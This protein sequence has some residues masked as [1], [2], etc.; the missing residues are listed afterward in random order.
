MRLTNLA[1][2]LTDA[3]LYVVEIAGWEERARG[4][5]GGHYLANRPTHV[6][7][8]H[9]AGTAE[10]RAAS[11]VN[12]MVNVSPVAPVANLYIAR[13]GVVFVMAAGPTNTNGK[14]SAPWCQFVAD[15]DM[16]RHAISIEVGNDGR[17][18]HYP[19][20]QQDSVL[21]TVATL[22]RSYGISPN[23]CRAHFEWSPDRKIDPSGTSRW[24]LRGG[25]WNMAAFRKDIQQALHDTP[26]L[27]A[28]AVFHPIQPYRNSD[29]RK[30]GQRLGANSTHAFT[31]SEEHVP[32]EATAVAVNVAVVGQD[33]NGHL[34][35]WPY[36][37]AYP[38]TSLVNFEREGAHNG[39]GVFGLVDGRLNVRVSTAAHVILDVTGYWT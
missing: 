7:V 14:G 13:N 37:M 25:K 12:Y 8:H 35:I 21:A 5:D 26:E 20:A 11:E 36:R 6:M 31:V 16:N 15:N 30:L 34:T 18:E 23:Y 2:H 27:K 3:G 10:A 29:T 33:K 28:G 22:C 4:G 1:K 24:A 32:R 19:K 17:G 9:T 39:A 38:N